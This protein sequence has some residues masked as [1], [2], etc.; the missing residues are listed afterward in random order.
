MASIETGQLSIDRRPEEVEH[1]LQQLEMMFASSAREAGIRLE[2][3][4]QP[5]L[6]PVLADCERIL[7]VLANL[8]ANSLKFTTSEGEVSVRAD[9]PV[10]DPAHVRFAVRDSGCGI[11]PEQL[12]HVFDRFWQA[13][14]GAKQ[15]GTGLGLAISK[16]IVEAHGGSIRA[17]SEVGRGSTFQFTLP[18]APP[19]SGS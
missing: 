19:A 15:R 12:P 10:D 4:A 9:I 3:A 18:V 11:P 17:E 16:G 5:R 7:Q 14:R 1:L 8:V 6:P 2:I 13:R